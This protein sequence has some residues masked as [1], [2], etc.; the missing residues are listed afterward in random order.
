[1]T[2]RMHYLATR[3]DSETLL[4]KA[5]RA[6]VDA[7]MLDMEDG[8]PA[9][10][11]EAARKT[12]LGALTTL[13]FGHRFKMIRINQITTDEGRADLSLVEGRPDALMLPKVAGPEDVREA[14]RLL[15]EAEREFGIEEGSIKL[16]VMLETATAV[17]QAYETLTASPRMEGALFGHADFT[18]DVGFEGIHGEGFRFHPTIIDYAHAQLIVAAAAAKVQ[19]VG[20]TMAAMKDTDTQ[21]AQMQRL[22]ALGYSGVLI[23]SPRQ[24]SIVEEA[25]RPSPVELEFAKGVVAAH[26]AS[27]AEG[28]SVS[29][30]ND[31]VVEEPFAHLADRVIERAGP[32]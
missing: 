23:L 3:A 20:G 15:G 9:G 16:Y 24:A 2:R 26:Q 5:S 27:M 10:T 1:M 6:P 28:V 8:V 29:T 18:V 32:V 11:K 13:D 25:A 30:F 17:M 21:F 12:L 31:W 4:E 22:F 14:D 19:L 7:L